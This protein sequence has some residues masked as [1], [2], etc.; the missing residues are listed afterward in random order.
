MK[1]IKSALAVLV[2]VSATADFW[3]QALP[4]PQ[5]NG[6]RTLADGFVF[7]GIADRQEPSRT[8]STRP[9][10]IERTAATVPTTTPVTG[11][12]VTTESPEVAQCR[13]RCPITS[14]Y[15]PVCGSDQQVYSNPGKLSCARFCGLDVDFLYS[16]PCDS[17]IRG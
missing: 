14:E 2:V 11:A 9:P 13:L 6:D 12:S 15:N 8:I 17:A 1:G 5:Q 16:G 10:P 7:D 3:A 4:R